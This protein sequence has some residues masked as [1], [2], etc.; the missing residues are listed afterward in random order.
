M[1][2][3]K[4]A[5]QKSRHD[6]AGQET[7]ITCWGYPN[8]RHQWVRKDAGKE[9][10]DYALENRSSG[11]APKNLAAHSEHLSE[12][13]PPLPACLTLRSVTR[14][15]SFWAKEVCGI[16]NASL[17][18]GGPPYKLE[19]AAETLENCLENMPNELFCCRMVGETIWGF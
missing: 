13:Q 6:P 1:P 9:L 2:V 17:G 15:K 11:K 19:L 10:W 3:G 4:Q 12:T 16:P 7:M 8:N 5:E 18:N 14:Q